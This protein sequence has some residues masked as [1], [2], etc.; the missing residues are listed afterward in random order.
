MEKYN[1]TGNL[2]IQKKKNNNKTA[3]NVITENLINFI[4]L[5]NRKTYKKIINGKII[6]FS[7]EK[8]AKHAKQNINTY[9]NFLFNNEFLLSKKLAKFN[10]NNENSE[11]NKS[12]LKHIQLTTSVCMG[13]KEKKNAAKKGNILLFIFKE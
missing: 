11:N 5:F 7:F 1:G 8:K 10:A 13:C 3:I 2:S 6:A 12:A 4:S 9:I